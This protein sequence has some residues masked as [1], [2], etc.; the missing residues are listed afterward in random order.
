MSD[1]KQ[2]STARRNSDPGG[3]SQVSDLQQKLG[4]DCDRRISDP[5][6]ASIRS[7]VAF[8]PPLAEVVLP[9]LAADADMSKFVGARTMLQG[10]VNSVF[11]RFVDTEDE[12]AF[13]E[14]QVMVSSRVIQT[15]VWLGLGINILYAVVEHL[16]GSGDLGPLIMSLV[17]VATVPCL[18]GK[19]TFRKFWIRRMLL[20]SFVLLLNLRVSVGVL[21]GRAEWTTI[22]ANSGYPMAY[23]LLGPVSTILLGTAIGLRP[24]RDILPG[25]VLTLG[26]CI[27]HITV[28]L[29]KTHDPN[30]S[31]KTTAT[32][33]NYV[34]TITAS[35]IMVLF[36]GYHIEK[37]MRSRWMWAPFE[38]VEASADPCKTKKIQEMQQYRLHPFLKFPDA[39][40]EE[41]FLFSELRMSGSTLFDLG[42]MVFC[43]CTAYIFI[44]AVGASID[45]QPL[46]AG[47]VFL[48]LSWK[49][50][51]FMRTH[52]QRCWIL[53]CAAV[54]INL[55]LLR[56]VGM[57]YWVPTPILYPF[58]SWFETASPTQ[59]EGYPMPFAV[60][61]PAIISAWGTM[62]GLRATHDITPVAV[63]T[64]IM[65][66]LHCW[67][68]LPSE[69]HA[70]RPAFLSCICS[71]T[72]LVC[73][74]GYFIESDIRRRWMWMRMCSQDVLAMQV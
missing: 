14:Y 27:A 73:F 62:M 4:P 37:T 22:V 3:G 64:C 39:E 49:P 6:C 56:V 17:S 10:R 46:I 19:T 74:V 31:A 28:I 29:H 70:I 25:T 2:K 45:I 36:S 69:P 7:A 59:G 54:Y 52:Y 32:H 30:S 23:S 11:M 15:A 47:G 12:A 42:R 50:H 38:P 20:W 65:G 67:V 43:F 44:G 26:I 1:G 33:T 13:L 58:K 66:M 41:A 5:G 55:R 51:F 21:F 68:V 63:V 57:P 71:Y 24:M 9:P 60:L 8:L 34:V 40:D 53:I 61:G 35:V 48:L 16:N 72:F 18:L